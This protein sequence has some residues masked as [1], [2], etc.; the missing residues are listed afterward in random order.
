GWLQLECD[1]EQ[2]RL[3]QL[4]LGTH[5]RAKD[6]QLLREQRVQIQRSPAPG[7]RAA[8]HQPSAARQRPDTLRPGRLA[9]MLYDDIDPPAV[10]EP[11][12]LPGGGPRW[13]AA[14]P[15]T[16]PPPPPA[17]LPPPPA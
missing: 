11:H 14:P 7:G 15:P 13:A 12:D 5:I 8:C 2:S 16:P 10:R 17:P 9:D 4:S 3:Q 1:E 6:R